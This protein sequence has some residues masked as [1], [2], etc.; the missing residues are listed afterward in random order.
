MNAPMARARPKGWAAAITR[1]RFS[2][3]FLSQMR[4]A[5]VTVPRW[6]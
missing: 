6:M 2:D 3:H 4:V 1:H 5:S